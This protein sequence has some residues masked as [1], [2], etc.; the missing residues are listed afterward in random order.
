MMAAAVA[1]V[2]RGGLLPGDWLSTI[3]NA[4]HI[5]GEPV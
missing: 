5:E 2:K 4:G 1:G 3:V